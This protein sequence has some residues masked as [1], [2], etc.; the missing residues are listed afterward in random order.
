MCQGGEVRDVER[1]Y[2]KEERSGVGQGGEGQRGE[3]SL[4]ALAFR[5]N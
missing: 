1:K 4:R 2:V 5:D 3:V